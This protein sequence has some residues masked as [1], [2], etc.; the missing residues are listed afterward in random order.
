MIPS[1]FSGKL[2]DT[3][4]MSFSRTGDD[5]IFSEVSYV[6]L[7]VSSPFVYV[8]LSYQNRR[9]VLKVPASVYVDGDRLSVTSQFS[10]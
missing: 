3:S 6:L 4:S 8:A 5:T 7:A 1:R 9:I 10:F 2:L